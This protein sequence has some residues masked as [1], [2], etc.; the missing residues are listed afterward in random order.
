MGKVLSLRHCVPQ[1]LKGCVK[2]TGIHTSGAQGPL[3]T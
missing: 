2:G 1:N 3:E